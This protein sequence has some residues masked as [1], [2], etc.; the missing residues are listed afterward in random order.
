MRNTMKHNEWSG[1]PTIGT[2][3]PCQDRKVAAL[4]NHLYVFGISRA[5][6]F[7][8]R[9]KRKKTQTFPLFLLL[10]AGCVASWAAGATRLAN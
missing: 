8:S 2:C 9:Q 4:S 1:S 10:S 6:L 3:E 5:S 7:N